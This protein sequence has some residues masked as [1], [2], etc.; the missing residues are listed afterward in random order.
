MTK[1]QKME[2]PTLSGFTIIEVV[3]VLA[4]AG[5][6]FLMVFIALPAMQ[7]NQRDTQRRDDY[8]ALSSAVTN[9]MTNHNGS[10]PADGAAPAV[11]KLNDKTGQGQ[12][13][14]DPDGR[15][16]DVRIATGAGTQAPE[17]PG[18][19]VVKNVKCDQNGGLTRA[20]GARNFAIYGKLESGDTYCQ[21][22]S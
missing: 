2:K 12:Y 8:A 20:N 6:I 16:Y 22:S 21:S 7:R 3:L 1:Q 15:G 5:L 4:I 17:L 10:L 14:Q 13:G 18:V 9:Y 19:V 11:L